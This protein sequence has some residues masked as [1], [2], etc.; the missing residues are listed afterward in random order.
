MAIAEIDFYFYSGT[1]NTLLVVE[2]MQRV[3][4]SHG[5]QVFLHEMTDTDPGKIDTGKTIGLA[6]PV[7]FQSTFPFIWK[8]LK[9]LPRA[10]GASVFMI[11][12][13][14]TFS[15]AIVGPLKKVLTSKGYNCIGASEVIMPNNWFPKTIHDEVNKEKI[16]TGMKKARKF[17]EELMEGTASWGRVPLLSDGLYHL[18]CNNFVMQRINLAEGRKI[19]C[20]EGKCRKCG[21]CA[22]LCPVHN[23]T[24]K[25]YPQWHDSCETCMRCLS[26]CPTNAV[27]I[28]GKKKY[29]LY[30][31]VKAE[32]L[33][34][35]D[36]GKEKE[37]E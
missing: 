33:F 15:G 5:I 30:R 2:E 18:C 6:F 21:L 23:I 29:E 3:F 19:T 35:K 27:F 20:D 17:A 16:N 22:R 4:S 11:D 7:A 31:A 36:Q 24:M 10:Q 26:F 37:S 32:R 25:E 1:G 13:M 12:T 14:M 28:P 34:S 8:F 9:N